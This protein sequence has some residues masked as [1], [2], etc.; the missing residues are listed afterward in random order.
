MMHKIKNLESSFFVTE[1]RWIGNLTRLI[2][3]KK[4]NQQIINF[5]KNIYIISLY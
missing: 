3:N 4:I 2:R 1:G 5:F